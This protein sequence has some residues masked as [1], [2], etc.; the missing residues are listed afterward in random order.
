MSFILKQIY[1]ANYRINLINKC[2]ERGL[3]ESIINS[4]SQSSDEVID[5]LATKLRSKTYN[6]ILG[7]DTYDE[8]IKETPFYPAYSNRWHLYNKYSV[9][10]LTRLIDEHGDEYSPTKYAV[11]VRLC[12]SRNLEDYLQIDNNEWLDN[13]IISSTCDAGRIVVMFKSGIPTHLIADYVMNVEANGTDLIDV[14]IDVYT[15]YHSLPTTTDLYNILSNTS[16]K[17][18]NTERSTRLI[19]TDT[20]YLKLCLITLLTNSDMNIALD[21]LTICRDAGINELT[22]YSLL[23]VFCRRGCLSSINPRYLESLG[24][25]TLNT[26]YYVMT[27]VDITEILC[28]GLSEHQ[29]S[30]ILNNLYSEHCNTIS[31][32]EFKLSF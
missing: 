13:L 28:L 23:E 22:T 6:S 32:R 26:I 7:F 15:I 18:I 27:Y 25:E 2:I 20:Y 8:D 21:V 4:L 9:S 24:I 19:R 3:D 5:E 1:T 31:N 10:S 17:F 29:L 12:N 16:E 11:L 14:A 30:D